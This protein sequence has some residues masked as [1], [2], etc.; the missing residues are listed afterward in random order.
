MTDDMQ[1]RDFSARTQESYIGAVKGLARFYNGS[2]DLFSEEEVRNFFLHLI[3]ERGAARSTVT[4]HLC[5]IKFFYEKTSKEIGL[6]SIS[7][8]RKRE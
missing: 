3:D 1:L 5:G 4:L 2:P 7:S 6:F 8:A